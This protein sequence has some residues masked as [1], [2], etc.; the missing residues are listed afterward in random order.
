M[1]R[2]P[3]SRWLVAGAALVMF[4][5][6]LAACGDD[7]DETTQDTTE[8][9]D[10]S[11]SDPSE[12]QSEVIALGGEICEAYGRV[13]E[14]GGIEDLLAMMADDVV[15]TDIELAADLTGKDALRG[16]LESDLFAGIDTSEC[17][18]GVGRG[19][20]MAGSYNLLDGNTGEAG[21][22][23]AAIHVTEDGLVDRQV[24]HYTPAV[25]DPPTPSSETVTTGVGLDYCHAW[26]DGADADEI[27]GF[28][29]ADP[30]L[31]VGEPISGAEDIRTFVES[32]DFDQNDCD[33]EGIEH[34]EW[35]AEASGFANSTTGVAI[36]GVSVVQ[37]EDDKIA[38]HY[39]Y[40]DPVA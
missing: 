27:L 7:S 30:T 36:E 24:N 23:I 17:G 8:V 4:A 26:D 2:Q 3:F 20:W 5:A 33:D 19:G 25:V 35:G 16:Y 15:V 1:T 9:P 37:W 11:S 38:T 18:V 21:T 6:P 22:G 29:T 14:P 39:V 32:F 10:G 40:M 34:G 31:V 28:M 12:P 13:Q